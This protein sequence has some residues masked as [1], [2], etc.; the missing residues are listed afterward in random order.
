[1]ETLAVGAVAL[2]FLR[3]RR[4]HLLP[5]TVGGLAGIA[6]AS[7]GGMLSPATTTPRKITR[8]R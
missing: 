2:A 7:M 1:M 5:L 4:G 3:G 6:L 8:A